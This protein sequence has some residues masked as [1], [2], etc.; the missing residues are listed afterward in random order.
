MYFSIR[1][2]WS[3]RRSK[4]PDLALI[5][6]NRY[7]KFKSGVISPICLPSGSV[8]DK[9]TNEV[10]WSLRDNIEIHFIDKI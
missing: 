6:L 2:G 4:S 5:E 9:P 10:I 3:L 7:V 8:Q 1:A